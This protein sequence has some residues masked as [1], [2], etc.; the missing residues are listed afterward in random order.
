MGIFLHIW[1][2]MSYQSYRKLVSVLKAKC[3][4][5][6]PVSVRRINLKNL[7]GCCYLHDKK[8]FIHINKNISEDSA[9]DTLLHEWAHAR[10][11]NHLLDSLN[12]QEF[13]ERSHDASWGVA[14]SEVYKIY[15]NFYL[16][17]V[18]VNKKTACKFQII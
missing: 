11:W 10:A 12:P 5:A 6:Y 8:F 9:I 2:Q 4:C 17:T 1:R 3:P 16:T 15:E 18:N 13:E 7:D 14:Y